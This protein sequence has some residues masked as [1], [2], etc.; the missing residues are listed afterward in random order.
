MRLIFISFEK[1][2]NYVEKSDENHIKSSILY[3]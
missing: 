3:K 1:I 2:E